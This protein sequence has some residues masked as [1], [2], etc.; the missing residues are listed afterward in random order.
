MSQV[1]GCQHI[2]VELI[3][4]HEI[5]RKY[6]CIECDIVAGCACDEDFAERFI[7]HQIDFATDPDSGLKVR[8]RGFQPGLCNECRGLEAVPA[9]RSDGYRSGG[10][11]Q[12]YYWREIYMGTTVRLDEWC[13]EHD[14]SWD[15]GH[16][17][18]RRQATRLR[19]AVVDE[20]KLLAKTSP[21]YDTS[22]Q[23]SLEVLSEAHVA[24][25]AMSAT[26][27]RLDGRPRLVRGEKTLAV[28]DWVAAE[29]EATGCSV[30]RCE[31]RPFHALFGILMWMWVQQPGDPEAQVVMFGGRDNIEA[32]QD[33]M[34][35]TVLPRDF[36]ARGHARRRR[37][38]LD[39]HLAWLADDSDGL[40]QM[41]DYW[42]APSQQLCAYLWAHDDETVSS[43]RK[44]IE[45]MGV[46]V[47]KRILRFLAEGYWDRYLGWPDLLVERNATWYLAEVKS[48]KDRL[49]GIQKAWIRENSRHLE[50][51][52]KIIKVH[53]RP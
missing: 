45:I 17:D 21:K 22:E 16:P 19:R 11:V 43:A 7:S 30:L 28:E 20:M 37:V 12:R 47:V 26:Y 32:D 42:I 31:S 8:S 27:V 36:G 53:R 3:N 51:P 29:L 5:I 24:T 10:K 14:H 50:L 15:S 38:E 35:W 1:G 49:S 44:L 34:I 33:G 2:N 41:F 46:E 23:S 39:E 18:V 4:P 13:S 48:S 52:V 9:P 25:I 40:L 6:R